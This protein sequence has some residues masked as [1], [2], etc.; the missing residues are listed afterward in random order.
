[1]LKKVGTPCTLFDPFGF[2]SPFTTTAKI[3]MKEMWVVG[4]DWDDPLP[5]DVVKKV[6]SWFSE[7]EQLPNVK[8]PRSLRM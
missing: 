4:V 1:M 7:L 5:S 2:L 3:L 6:N 8:I